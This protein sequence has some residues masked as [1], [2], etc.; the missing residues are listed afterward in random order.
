MDWMLVMN[1]GYYVVSYS[2]SWENKFLHPINRERSQELRKQSSR[3]NSFCSLATLGRTLPVGWVSPRRREVDI[4]WPLLPT[5][6]EQ[7]NYA[8][9]CFVNTS[10]LFWAEERQNKIF[11]LGKKKKRKYTSQYND[12]KLWMLIF[13]LQAGL[14]SIVCV[15]RE[16][17]F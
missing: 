13:C 15:L 9:V 8:Q 2:L 7:N 16:S 17:F 10:S 5:T 3:T 12:M 4:N 11:R 1:V 14:K 6:G